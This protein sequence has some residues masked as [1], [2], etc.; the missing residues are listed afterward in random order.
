VRNIWR[1]YGGWW[2]G[3]PATLKPPREAT[4]AAEIAALSGGPGAR[5]RRALERAEGAAAG[6]AGGNGGDESLRLAC[7]LVEWAAAA[8]DASG[9]SDASERAEVHAA[10]ADLYTQRRAVELSLMSKGVYGTAATDSRQL[11]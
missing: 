6:G 8:A 11:L 4:V 3:N 1:L 10:R 5:A 7:Q 2:D 9:G